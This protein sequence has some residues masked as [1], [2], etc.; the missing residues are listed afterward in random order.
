MCFLGV[1]LC[2]H[3]LLFTLGYSKFLTCLNGK[4]AD[5]FFSTLK[6]KI[7]HCRSNQDR[8]LEYY[9]MI[10]YHLTLVF[11]LKRPECFTSSSYF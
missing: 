5:C 10:L 6:L 4:I 11:L 7:S 9:L 8:R 1:E 2:V 3:C